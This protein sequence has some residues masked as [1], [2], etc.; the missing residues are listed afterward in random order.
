MRRAT[1]RRIRLVKKVFSLGLAGADPEDD[2]Y[3]ADDLKQA[4][5]F[6]HYEKCV[7]I[8]DHWSEISPNAR[9]EAGDTPFYA[10]CLK[11]LQGEPEVETDEYVVNVGLIGLWN[12][13]KKC[14][15]KK[16]FKKG[17][18]DL[19]VKILYYK[20]GDVNVVAL[21]RGDG[22]GLALIHVA[23]EKNMVDLA[24]WLHARQVNVHQE[25]A[26]LKRTPLM[27]AARKGHGDMVHR[28]LHMGAIDTINKQDAE[29]WTALH[30]VATYCDPEYVEMMMICGANMSIR[31][32]GNRLPLEEAQ[33][34]GRM[35][36]VQAI[37]TYK[38]RSR[39]YRHQI[40][41]FNEEV[42]NGRVGGES[43][44]SGS[45]QG[46]SIAGSIASGFLSLSRSNSMK[47]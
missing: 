36:C 38:D 8:M 46:K 19:V 40:S 16:R 20:G 42:L 7:D 35:E 44:K 30:F 12:K 5:V 11:A 37:M 13:M 21:D 14:L 9:C 18:I 25:T 10:A 15:K 22:D 23:A 45:N 6:G 31:N 41:Y 39:L 4:A 29:G 33:T 26:T 3:C 1:A 34:R 2:A 47:K 17:K 32:K 43:V 24:K 27:V 28:L